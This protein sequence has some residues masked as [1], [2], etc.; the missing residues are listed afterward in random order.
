MNGGDIKGYIK[1]RVDSWVDDDIVYKKNWD[2]I[3]K[4]WDV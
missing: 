2:S 4:D 3:I 1:D